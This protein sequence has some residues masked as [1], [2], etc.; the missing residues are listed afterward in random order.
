MRSP[1]E[2]AIYFLGAFEARTRMYFDPVTVTEVEAFLIGF[3][4]ACQSHGTAWGHDAVDQVVRERGWTRVWGHSAK[5][6]VAEMRSRGPSEE[7]AAEKLIRI[8][9]EA[10]QRPAT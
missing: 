7:A 8:K 5:D 4:A 9:R 2:E 1:R 3:E 6:L 10:L